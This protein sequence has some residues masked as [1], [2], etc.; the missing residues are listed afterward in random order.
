MNVDTVNSLFPTQAKSAITSTGKS[1]SGAFSLQISLEMEKAET[2]AKE[3]TVEDVKK[4]FWDYLN[5]LDK[6]LGGTINVLVSDSAWEKM[7]ADPEYKQKMMDLCKRDLCAPGWNR[8]PNPAGTVIQINAGGGEEYIA[9]SQP[10]EFAKE[11]GSANTGGKGFWERR[12]DKNKE[13]NEQ[14][15]ERALGKRQQEKTELMRFLQEY[16]TPSTTT[17]GDDISFNGYS[18]SGQV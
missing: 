17:S 5:S 2:P 11:N 15:V 6:T 3:T 14:A 18:W 16:A 1:I 13:A 4:E 8:M 7:A 10:G 9:R 12:A